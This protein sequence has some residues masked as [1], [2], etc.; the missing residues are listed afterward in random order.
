M[1][2]AFVDDFVPALV[3]GD[4]VVLL[5]GVDGGPGGGPPQRRMARIIERYDELR[6]ALERAAR[7][8]PRRPLRAAR[9]RPPLP[10]PS[11]ILCCMGG[12][13]EGVADGV[14]KGIDMFV[15]A[16]SA[17]IGPGD[18]VALPEYQCPIFHHEAE[19]GVVI[20]RRTRSVG[21]AEALASVFGYVNFIDVSG[22]GFPLEPSIVSVPSFL[23][24][25]FDT[26]APLGPWITTADE[27]A[28]VG[29]V[30]IRLWVNDELRQDYSTTDAEHPV[31]RVVAFAS[32]IMT[33][34]PG[35]VIACGTNHQGL[36]A[37]QDRDRVRMEIDG[38]GPLTVEVR[39]P[40]KRVWPR[41][42]DRLFAE[43]VRSR[44]L[45]TPA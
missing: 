28:D 15:K 2:L 44:R 45:P 5:E 29:R 39:D 22:R 33:L 32:S 14:R 31:S 42:T 1:K 34:E 30:Q 43:R 4:E 13:M 8:G 36:G 6:P 37:L 23:G 11:K 40:L 26:F 3:V 27:I 35:D 41:G 20:G 12:Y 9:L 18:T 24:K 16:S 7:S 25:S 17:V 38:L 10:A 19:L 21:E